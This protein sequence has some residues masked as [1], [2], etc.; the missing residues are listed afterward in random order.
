MPTTLDENSIKESILTDV[1]QQFDAVEVFD[2]IHS[3]QDYV[4][5]QIR[6]NRVCV[7]EHQIAGKG[8]RGRKWLAA[9]KGDVLFSLSWMYD[10]APNALNGL[11]LAIVAE[12]AELLAT[13]YDIPVKIKWPNDLLLSGAK[14]AGFI[15]DLETGTHC[16][17]TIGMGLN[18]MDR[19]NG[20]LGKI[21]QPASSLSQLGLQNINR[22]QLIAELVNRLTRLLMAYPQLGFLAYKRKWQRYAAY[23]GESV[24]LERRSSKETKTLC[25]GLLEGVD[26]QGR[27]CVR[28]TSSQEVHKIIDSELSLRP[29]YE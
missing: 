18:V 2:V 20:F 16:R 14:L 27:L 8:R 21:D 24:V 26:E 4:K 15:V 22:N 12:V 7:A 6:T 28:D 29:A 1:L 19:N 25:V 3:T 13:T 5:S 9:D 17:I 11:S 23:T 10:V